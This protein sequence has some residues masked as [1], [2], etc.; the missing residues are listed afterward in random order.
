MYIIHLVDIPQLG[1]YT[2]IAT[3]VT[4]CTQAEEIVLI[5]VTLTL[6]SVSINLRL[7]KDNIYD[8]YDGG[9]LVGYCVIHIHEKAGR[10]I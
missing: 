2:R 8:I 9:L 4:T 5:Y 10:G 1:D 6:E 3:M 7:G